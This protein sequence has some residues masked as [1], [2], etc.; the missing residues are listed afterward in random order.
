MN[1]AE[2]KRIYNLLN[3]REDIRRL[4]KAEGLDEE[5]LL[6]ILSQKIVRETK[7][8]YYEIKKRANKLLG[9][10]LH[11]KK[12]TDIARNEG[13]PPLLTASLMLQHTG[14][15]KSQFRAYVDDPEAIEDKRL[16]QEIKDAIRAE[17]IYSPDGAR[18]QHGRGKDVEWLVKKWLDNKN[19][20]YITEYDAKKG[21]HTKTPDFK[22]DNP[23][24]LGDR[25]I[26]WV[27]CKGSFADE[28]EYKRDYGKQLLHYVKL[29]GTGM[30]IYWY[31][32]IEDMPNHLM[33]KNILLADRSYVR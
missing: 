21:E 16:R 19:V 1:S 24:K 11:G 26:N 30:V 17:V 3:S 4:H 13:F 10:W 22:L 8:N 33:D 25:W 23:M 18:V 5:L 14:V 27:E 12:F 2:Y 20:K 7:R 32:F 31:G 28:V 9:E 29:F 15:S 6:V